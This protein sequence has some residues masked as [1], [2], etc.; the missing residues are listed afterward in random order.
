MR[1]CGPHARQAGLLMRG[2]FNLGD[3]GDYRVSDAGLHRDTAD[4]VYYPTA[5]LVIEIVSPHD[6]T[7]DKLPFY[8]A[9]GVEELLIVDPET[10]TVYLV[11]RQR[12]RRP[13]AGGA[14][15][16]ARSER[17][18]AHRADRLAV[19]SRRAP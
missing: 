12:A 4:R 11:G 10:Q 18:R 13:R 8:A 6:E 3:E 15:P 9:R 1:C 17:P 2:A 7:S 14:R 5:A 16:T 19:T